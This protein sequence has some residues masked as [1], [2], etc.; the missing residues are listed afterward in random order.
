MTAFFMG[1]SPEDIEQHR[2]VHAAAQHDVNR[3]LMDLPDAQLATL[4]MIL[5]GI[6][7]S[8]NAHS[9]AANLSGKIATIRD[10]KF[11]I[12]AACGA[13]H[14]E[15][16]KKLIE[17]ETSTA[18]DTVEVPEHVQ[19]RRKVD[20]QAENTEDWTLIGSSEQL[21]DWEVA[22]MKEFNLDDL[23][24]EASFQLAGFVC[25]GC[26]MN[27]RSIADRMLRETGPEGCTGCIH[28][29]KWG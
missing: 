1:P 14:D 20:A 16:A 29:M 2:A 19:A 26:G 18:E 7:Q 21:K 10:F 27:Y 28:K 25:L 17:E 11:S 6:A 13:N 9:L 4:E 23:R 8:D 15:E 22:R 24:E 5:T 12:C 3:L